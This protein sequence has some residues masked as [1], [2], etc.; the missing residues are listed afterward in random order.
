MSLRS[1]IA[2]QLGYPSGI[3]GRLLMKLLNQGNAG[4]NDVTFEQL[5]LQPEDSILE[6]GFGGGYL[7]NKIVASKI[8]AFVAGIDPQPDVLQLGNKKFR[9]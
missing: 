6:I 8:P 3:F 9:Q 4:M 7:L 2:R 1:F 5:N